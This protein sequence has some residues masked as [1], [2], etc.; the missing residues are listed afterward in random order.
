MYGRGVLKRRREGATVYY[1]IS[2]PNVVTLCRT[3]CV[4]IAGQ[5]DEPAVTSRVMKRFM[6]AKTPS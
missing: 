1:A 4:H 5:Q 6:P 2:D 3:A